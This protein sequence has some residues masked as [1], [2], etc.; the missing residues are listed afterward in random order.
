MRR[1]LLLALLAVLGCERA[2]SAPQPARRR[3]PDPAESSLHAR[4]NQGIARAR[5]R[6]EQELEPPVG[7]GPQPCPDESLAA[8]SAPHTLILRTRVVR[9]ES[10]SPLPL[11]LL[12]ALESD[13]FSTITAHLSG[14]AAALW[15][16]THAR[17]KSP[18]G[19]RLAL[20]AL[21]ALAERPYL[22]ELRVESYVEPKLFRRKDAPKSE[23]EAGLVAGRLVIYDLST[24]RP[25]CQA[26][27][28]VRGD[29]KDA[30][31]RKRLREQTRERLRAALNDRTY[32][33]LES[34]LG[35]ISS[36]FVL[37]SRERRTDPSQRWAAPGERVASA[38]PAAAPARR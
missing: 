16:P 14:G 5:A 20:E 33:A 30:P 27:L 34:A 22:A 15:D 13:E 29:A 11:R 37:P 12:T 26:K 25:L 4:I 8:G 17:P 3:G 18:E 23:W 28:L 19:A 36:R 7:K 24:R 38:A 6:I 21:D 1:A 32:A 2:E 10:R 35:S 31:I 9:S